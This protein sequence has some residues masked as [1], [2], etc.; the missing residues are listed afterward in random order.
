MNKKTIKNIL[1][2][3]GFILLGLNFV[4]YLIDVE[5]ILEA[6]LM[7][8]F[9]TFDEFG[10]L[11]SLLSILS[12]ILLTF[13]FLIK[14]DNSSYETE[15]NINS[16]RKYKI[17]RIIGYIPFLGVLIF[18]SFL[19]NS[20]ND[21]FRKI[22][23]LSLFVWPLY[24]V[25]FILIIKNSSKN[26]AIITLLA[27]IV[28]FNMNKFININVLTGWKKINIGNSEFYDNCILNID[29]DGNKQYEE[30]EIKSSGKYIKINGK[31]YVVNKYV[32]N[33]IDKNDASILFSSFNND[34]NVNQYHILDL[35]QDNIMEI[36]HRTY[37]N[38]ISPSCS[39]Y[40]IYNFYNNELYQVGSMGF[41]GNMPNEIYVK[42]NT[43][44]FE[45]WPYETS[46]N[47][48]VEIVENLQLNY[49]ESNN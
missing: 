24:L 41:I 23:T 8:A 36:I 49:L 37:S 29:L 33:E 47:S 13:G 45:Y 12:T 14:K 32:E 43:L 25:G 3:T 44:K 17:L 19:A 10:K 4:I 46:K 11:E 2:I 7:M 30:I 48:R 6:L 22:H 38:M 39:Y 18:V 27:I 16:S 35:N 31:K 42:N 20:F 34:Y 21:F 5:N 28:L 40:T 1:I 26:R 15:N 9:E